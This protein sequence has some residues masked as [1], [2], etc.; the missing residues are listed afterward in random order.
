RDTVGQMEMNYRRFHANDPVPT[1][2]RPPKN[3]NV[4]NNGDV[5]RTLYAITILLNALLLFLVQPM[6]AK[7]LLPYLGGTP[8]VWNTCMVFFQAMLMGG[9]AYSHW[10]TKILGARRQIIL[11]LALLISAV[12]VFPIGVSEEALKS[13]EAGARPVTWLLWQLLVTVGL[14]F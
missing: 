10:T 3:L 2:F 8:S 1:S 13:L 11:H 14:P 4:I 5:M 9:Y 12:I 6:I 7:M